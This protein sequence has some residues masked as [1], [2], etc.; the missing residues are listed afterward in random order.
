MERIPTKIKFLD[1]EL[2]EEAIFVLVDYD[3]KTARYESTKTGRV[4]VLYKYGLEQFE[5]K[6]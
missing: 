4:I 2:G 6:E 1:P 5:V 3:E